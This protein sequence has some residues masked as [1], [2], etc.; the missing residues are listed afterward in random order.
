[1]AAGLPPMISTI[2]RCNM[3]NSSLE[4]HDSTCGANLV[5]ACRAHSRLSWQPGRPYYSLIWRTEKPIITLLCF[6][7]L[8]TEIQKSWNI[9]QTKTTKS[10]N[11]I[12]IK[13]RSWIVGPDPENLW[14][15]SG[16]FW[17]SRKFWNSTVHF[18]KSR[19]IE[20]EGGATF[21]CFCFAFLFGEPIVLKPKSKKVA[22]VFCPFFAVLFLVAAQLS[23]EV[24]K[25][26]PR[27]PKSRPR[28]QI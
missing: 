14:K 19:W 28:F 20:A 10:R 1:M 21:F 5:S 17:K 9:I 23:P 13:P 11:L 16:E 8:E 7:I 2:C 4:A 18:W 22:T 24:S 25:S 12:Q 27:F 3:Y 26:R 15:T 6:R